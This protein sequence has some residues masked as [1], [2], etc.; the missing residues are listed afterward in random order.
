MLCSKK[1]RCHHVK[2]HHHKNC[3]KLSKKNVNLLVHQYQ[4]KIVTKCKWTRYARFQMR[5]QCCL[6]QKKICLGKHCKSERG[7]CRWL[8]YIIT[9]KN[10]KKM[11]M[12]KSCKTCKKITLL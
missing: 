4:K 1:K 8:G 5:K 11:F 3:K 10:W 9:K 6:F 12:E 2:K 7:I